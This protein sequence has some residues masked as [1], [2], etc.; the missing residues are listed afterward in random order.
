[1]SS[2]PGTALPAQGFFGRQPG[3]RLDAWIALNVPALTGNLERVRA[4]AGGRPVM[5]VVKANAYGHGLVP[6]AENLVRAGVDALM[7]VNTQEAE[8]LRS[9]GVDAPIMNFGPMLGTEAE[10]LIERQ[11]E[12]MVYTREAVSALVA[13]AAM[14]VAEAR[15][16][17]HIDTGLGRVGVPY[18]DAA[19]LLEWIGGRSRVR[20]VGTSTTL[21]EDP[22]F[23]R[24]QLRRFLE[25]CSAA[26]TAGIDLGTRHVASSAALMDF[27]DAHLDMVRPGTAIYGH[28]P[29]EESRRRDAEVGLQPVLSLHA[30]IAQVKELQPGDSVGYHR[31]YTASER[32]TIAT[33]PVGYSD[34]YPPEVAAAGGHVWIR[35]TACPLV[36]SVTSNHCEVRVPQE[37]GVRPGETATLIA[38]GRETAPGAGFRGAGLTGERPATGGDAGRAGPADAGDAGPPLAH[39]VAAWAGISTYRLHMQ[40][41]PDLPRNLEGLRRQG[42]GPGRG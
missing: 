23:D 40:L 2:R 15:V 21:T 41:N 37:L 8:A 4:R 17:V 19:A 11:I 27:P 33:L 31:A 28:Y 35:G 32:Q 16:H 10:Y 30:R 29:S 9:A 1:M 24:E 6:V 12:Q 20:I 25:I 18:R 14:Q 5:A 39:V 22:E 13:A 7:V 34:G 38:S 36:G 42:R 3:R 26:E